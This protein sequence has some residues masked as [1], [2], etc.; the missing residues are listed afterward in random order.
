MKKVLLLVPCF[1]EEDR[2]KFD[3]FDEGK[4][5]NLA[6]GIELNYL[7]ANDG[8]TDGTQ[9]LLNSYCTRTGSFTYP[10]LENFGKANILQKA[11]QENL[12]LIQAGTYDWIGY[13][14][15][16]LAT[17]LEE[18]PKMLNYLEV[19]E[20]PKVNSIWGSRINR[21]GSNIKRQMHRHYL[22]R[23]FVTIVSNVLDVKA[24]DSQCGAKLF[25][26]EAL[27]V[28][29]KEPFISRWI[30]DVEIL[31]RLKSFSII[32]HPISEWSDVPGSK[33]KVFREILR[34]AYDLMKIRQKYISGRS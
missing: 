21:L 5:Y 17:P 4:K 33:V 28:A 30:F 24:Y 7:F 29:F 10:S 9:A 25:T 14:D 13:W 19:W 15:A 18:I 27:E 6:R 32:E 22:G 31:L 26:Q 11:C 2:L 1:N 23:I 8:S 20:L 3:A 12:K 16:D 34:V